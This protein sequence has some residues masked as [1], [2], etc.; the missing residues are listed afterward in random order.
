MKISR[1]TLPAIVATAAIAACTGMTAAYAAHPLVTD[2][3][4]TQGIG[5]NQLELNTDRA[6]QSGVSN[7]SA[8]V[9]YTYGLQD[10]LDAFITVPASTTRPSGINDVVIGAKW[11]FMESDYTSLGLKPELS[12]PTGD[13]QA[14]RGTGRTGAG[15]SLLGSHQMDAWTFLANIGCSLKRYAL[16]EDRD[17]NRR[18]VWR[19]SFA[20]I[21]ALSEQWKVAVDAGAARN[22]LHAVRTNP[23][24]ILFGV[25]Y[26]PSSKV[27][28]DAGVKAGLNSAEVHRQAGVGVTLR[29]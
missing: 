21:H 19:T 26:S 2:D 22:E 16:P 15:L 6:R 20:A 12:F 1:T 10:A 28:L 24:F 27:D 5:N 8:S 13:E 9:T 4:G 3:T 14:G 7:Q 25:I 18:V 17:Q 29:F 23:A 11:R